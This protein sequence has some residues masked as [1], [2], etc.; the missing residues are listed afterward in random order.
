MGGGIS[1][2]V[3]RVTNPVTCCPALTAEI[4]E[5]FRSS[6]ISFTF[7]SAS[8]AISAISAVNMSPQFRRRVL[9]AQFHDEPRNRVTL[10][11]PLLSRETQDAV[12]VGIGIYGQVDITRSQSH[13]GLERHR[14]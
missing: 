12:H 14:R 8:S 3:L 1:G 9:V 10:S 13:L 11:R 6:V 7:I 5:S 4:A 2:L